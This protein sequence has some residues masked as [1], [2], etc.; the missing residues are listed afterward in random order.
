MR[1]TKASRK[2][3]AFVPRIVF[4]L[5]AV[6]SVIPLCAA[7]GG[8]V[9]QAPADAAPPYGGDVAAAFDGVASAMADA[10]ELP[11]VVAAILGDG[12]DFNLGVGAACFDGCAPYVPD[13]GVS[14]GSFSVA[15]A[16]F[17]VADASFIHGVAA[18]GFDAGKG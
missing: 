11:F 8:S 12:G 3:T 16:S 14:D 6:A 18:I 13:A 9:Q 2:R 5:G 7:C 10:G 1:S 4:E 15:D 17:G